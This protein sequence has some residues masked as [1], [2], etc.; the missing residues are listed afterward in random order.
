MM[1]TWTR[2]ARSF[3]AYNAPEME[4]YKRLWDESRKD[5]LGRRKMGLAGL[6]LSELRAV[7]FLDWRMLRHGY[8]GFEPS[9][10]DMAYL[11]ELIDAIR[12]RL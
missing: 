8:C 12:S 1:V 9:P 7:L 2:F 6:S 11:W 10:S 5:F 4:Q 3:I